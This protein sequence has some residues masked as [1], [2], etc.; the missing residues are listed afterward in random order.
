MSFVVLVPN[1]SNKLRVNAWPIFLICLTA[2]S[3]AAVVLT[4]SRLVLVALRTILHV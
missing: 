4:L 1:H 2:I 3:T